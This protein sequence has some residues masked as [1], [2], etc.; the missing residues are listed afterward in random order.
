MFASLSNEPTH[1]ILVSATNTESTLSEKA[2]LRIQD[3]ISQGRLR[4]GTLISEPKLAREL[5]ISRTALR[6][7]LAR[8]S[9]ES[10]VERYPRGPYGRWRVTVMTKRDVVDVYTCRGALEGLAAVLASRVASPSELETLRSHLNDTRSAYDFESISDVVA[11]TTLFHD[12]IINASGNHRLKSLIA[13]L[14]TR[15][16]ENRR[17]MLE[18]GTRARSFQSQNERL[19]AFIAAGDPE[20][21]ERTAREIAEHDIEA[22]LRLYDLGILSEEADSLL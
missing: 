17:L 5:D 9:A 22:I 3:A 12:G 1:I 14:R 18:H 21:A 11:A 16:I 7:A 10:Y 8:L 2:Y 4:P 15:V 6:E 19:L 20:G 13:M